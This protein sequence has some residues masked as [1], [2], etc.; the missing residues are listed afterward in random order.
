VDEL[1]IDNAS[2]LTN[3]RYW[4]RTTNWNS[5]VGC[6]PGSATVGMCSSGGNLD[7]YGQAKEILC[8]SRSDGALVNPD[9][10]SDLRQDF[11]QA[12]ALC[13]RDY[14]VSEFCSSGANRDC[15]GTNLVVRCRHVSAAYKIDYDHCQLKGASSWTPRL[16]AT[17][18]N[19]V[20]IGLCSS[21]QN[22]DCGKNRDMTKSATF[23][24][25]LPSTAENS[26]TTHNLYEFFNGGQQLIT[27]YLHENPPGWTFNGSPFRLYNNV[28]PDRVP[29]MRCVGNNA[30]LA[31][32]DPNCEG[33]AVEGL[34]GYLSSTTG[35]PVYRCLVNGQYLATTDR[36]LCTSPGN[37]IELT[38][39][40]AP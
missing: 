11:S 2:V 13:P 18:S 28:G 20:I 31:S 34:M 16:Q 37:Y 23:C 19:Q 27:L 35:T 7:C 6:S 4:G 39:G 8:A 36:V 26:S 10:I 14:V 32:T 17:A 5:G 22:P 3:D 25:L 9:D 33:Q 38:L 15:A 24:P 40:Y 1:P 29:L 21:G 30:R 12:T